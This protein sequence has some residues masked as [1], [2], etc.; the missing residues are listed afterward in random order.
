MPRLGLS[1]TMA[2]P[3]GGISPGIT[4]G[5]VY[6]ETADEV[7]VTN[8]FL[9]PF[10][11]ELAYSTYGGGF[12]DFLIR[13]AGGGALFSISVNEGTYRSKVVPYTGGG[14]G[15]LFFQQ[16]R[17][18]LGLEFMI[19]VYFDELSNPIVGYVAAVTVNLFQK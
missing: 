8:G 2:L 15:F 16:Q 19:D 10:A 1:Y 3:K 7:S 12:M 13:A 18:S 5:T 6:F 17:F 11:F 4:V 14:G 9:S